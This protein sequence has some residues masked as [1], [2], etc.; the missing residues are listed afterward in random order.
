MH[1]EIQIQFTRAKR[2]IEAKWS[3]LLDEQMDIIREQINMEAHIQIDLKEKLKLSRSTL[4][5]NLNN[6]SKEKGEQYS[7]VMLQSQTK[8]WENELNKFCVGMIID[9]EA[10]AGF[11]LQKAKQA[12]FEAGGTPERY[13]Q[14]FKPMEWSTIQQ[15]VAVIKSNTN[16]GKWL[17]AVNA[18]K[19]DMNVQFSNTNRL[20]NGQIELCDDAELQSLLR[21]AMKVNMRYFVECLRNYDTD[22]KILFKINALDF[23][24][25]NFDNWIREFE[26][27]ANRAFRNQYRMVFMLTPAYEPPPPYS[28]NEN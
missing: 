6:L 26:T 9:G 1:K 11:H 15:D 21:N 14:T 8:Q 5:K 28:Q 23:N 13:I 19:Q 18:Y 20:I 12:V 3:S 2:Q 27:N 24:Q 16:D 25:S 7:T 17:A 4:A 22:Q 10:F